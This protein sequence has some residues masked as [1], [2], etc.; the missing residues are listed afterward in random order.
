LTSS[1][2]NP[3]AMG[4]GD[5]QGF[6][7][8]LILLLLVVAWGSCDLDQKAKITNDLET[9]PKVEQTRKSAG[10]DVVLKELQKELHSLHD[11]VNHI[12]L[13]ADQLH[14]D[15][16]ET[17]Q[18][19][20]EQQSKGS[21]N[22]F[23]DYGVLFIILFIHETWIMLQHANVLLNP[24]CQ[25]LDRNYGI[26]LLKKQMFWV[27]AGVLVAYWMREVLS[28]LLCMGLVSKLTQRMIMISAIYHF[29]KSILISIDAH[30]KYS[31]K[32]GIMR[33]LIDHWHLDETIDQ[34][35]SVKRVFLQG[36]DTLTHLMIVIDLTKLD[37][38]CLSIFVY[39]FLI[40][41]I[42][43]VGNQ[44]TRKSTATLFVE[45]FKIITGENKN[46][47]SSLISKSAALDNHKSADNSLS[48]K[49]VGSEDCIVCKLL[50]IH[51][52]DKVN[53]SKDQQETALPVF[54]VCDVAF[55]GHP[56]TI[57]SAMAHY[58]PPSSPEEKWKEKWWMYPFWPALLVISLIHMY[59]SPLFRGPFM[60][61]D[62]FTFNGISN[63]A[64]LSRA[65]GY[66]FMLPFFRP[67]IA[68]NIEEIIRTADAQGVKVLGLGA[69]NKAEFI[70]HG[71]KDAVA[72]VHPKRTRVVHG[73][74]LTAA[75]VMENISAMAKIIE[76]EQGQ[77][78]EV[79]LT[80]P[81][82]KIGRA[83]ALSLCSKGFTVW[84]FTSS[85]E[86]FQ[87]LQ[88][89]VSTLVPK[90]GGGRL[91]R[92]SYLWEG[93]RCSLWVV[94]KYDL[95]VN[96]H[97][98]KNSIAVNFAVPCPLED[99]HRQDIWVVDG[100]VFEMDMKQCTKRLFPLLLPE[101]QVYACHAA[102]MVHY[103]QKWDHHEVSDIDISLM[104][105]N[106]KAAKACGFSIPKFPPRPQTHQA[107]PLASDSFAP[108]PSSVRV[109]I[110]GGGSSGLAMG[111][112]LL[113]KGV[114]REEVLIL[115]EQAS[116]CGSWRKQ[117]ASMKITT[118][119]T[120]CSLPHYPIPD[121]GFGLEL[122]GSDFIQYLKLYAQHFNLP[123]CFQTSVVHAY[124][125]EISGEWVLTTSRGML[126]CQFLV[127]ATGKNAVPKLPIDAETF[128]QSFDGKICHSSEVKDYNGFLSHGKD[129]K[130]IVIVGMGNSAC[131]LAMEFLKAY[132]DKKV[133]L[134]IRSV[135]PIVAREWGPFAVEW[136][137]RILCQHLPA[138]LA[139]KVVDL[140]DVVIHGW[141]WKKQCF[142]QGLP[143][144]RAFSSGRVPIIDKGQ[145]V[146]SLKAEKIVVHG[147]IEKIEGSRVTFKSSSLSKKIEVANEQ[148][149]RSCNFLEVDTLIFATGFAPSFP[150]WLDSSCNPYSTKKEDNSIFLVG[151]SNGSALIPLKKVCK[152]S[153]LFA[154]HIYESRSQ[155]SVAS[156]QWNVDKG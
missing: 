46:G 57:C 73:N 31:P 149:L 122:S 107:L 139:D 21:G 140:F 115:E 154:Q 67:R 98:P 35:I 25:H 32:L 123:I 93:A 30:R 55:V 124:K 1:T 106:L 86:R 78:K 4:M 71:G 101:N 118:R 137:S 147:P 87:A 128:T 96:E 20:G 29:V 44:V 109:I 68:K 50:T 56:T 49:H 104:Q 16:G 136:V 59:I 125:E 135:P 146:K 7:L 82:S 142:P 60:V 15:A 133:H 66:H 145:L 90:G 26:A 80:G 94:G 72:N 38:R 14:I 126:R 27:I 58:A 18:N 97:M 84:C 121:E 143:S 17:Q 3:Q 131:D 11:V 74:T 75:A 48:Q 77:L 53:S 91:V 144:W 112:S 61:W 70:N 81:T 148:D 10:K 64:W 132:P 127:I 150:N 43:A 12:D 99:S 62:I 22:T 9:L 39:T 52:V 100:G 23:K 120:H 54:P 36:F 129:D 156:S 151:F 119:K 8:H 6:I 83:V 95:K 110:V 116:I 51:R 85:I 69:L 130:E 103:I 105:N 113:E 45:A 153:N 88:A 108:L 28:M 117:D 5:M 65:F 114:P 37:S 47:W 33:L 24:L 92:A 141:N 138:L 111:A 134:S 42:H 2:K 79:F 13:L 155:S 89:E 34:F 40:W 63:Q 76:V 41:V 102:A 152:E 19:Q